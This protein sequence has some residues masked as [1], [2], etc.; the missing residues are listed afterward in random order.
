MDPTKSRDLITAIVSMDEDAAASIVET[1]LDEGVDPSAIVEVSRA[2]MT[3]VGEHYQAGEA[4][5]PEL[6]M[7]GEI[8]R[9]ISSRLKPHFGTGV[10]P[11][12]GR[13]VFGTVR[14]DIHDIGK[15]IVVSLLGSA[16]FEVVD[17]GVD[18]PAERFVA[19]V[20][21]Q[22]PCAL[23]LSCLLTLGFEAM[24]ETIDAIV[25]AGL[26][27]Q[28]RVMIGG[29]PITHRV[30]EYVHADG[31]GTD[32]AQALELALRWTRAGAS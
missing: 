16:G 9:S 27:S 12:L 32:A 28:V 30:C 10:S 18:V 17:L 4:F 26:R 19:A 20:G 8:M 23:G 29:A 22:R 24:K 21:K 15:D 13:V 7:A 11:S 6:I 25:A 5:I 14:G 1:W 2:A 3:V 31:F